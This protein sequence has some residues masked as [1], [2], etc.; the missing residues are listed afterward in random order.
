[1]RPI[2]QRDDCFAACIATVL[3]LGLDDLPRIPPVTDD[4]TRFDRWRNWLNGR[5]WDL[6]FAAT[7]VP[8]EAPRGFW[9]A[10]HATDNPDVNHAVVWEGV[11]PVWN[12]SGVDDPRRLGEVKVG[13]VLVPL[14][15]AAVDSPR[16]IPPLLRLP[17]WDRRARCGTRFAHGRG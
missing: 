2:R 17:P 13:L 12:P 8:D 1:M 9:I 6:I 16:G 3:G 4:E 14:E 7:A 5:G 10:G 15:P 11:E